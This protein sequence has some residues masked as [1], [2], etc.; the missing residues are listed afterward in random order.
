MGDQALTLSPY[1]S[2]RLSGSPISSSD[3]LTP[4]APV[5]TGVPDRSEAK[6]DPRSIE[7]SY[8]L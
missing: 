1:G 4:E 3:H 8:V 5:E 7:N 6:V 2:E